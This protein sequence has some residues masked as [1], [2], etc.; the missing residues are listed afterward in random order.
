MV[1]VWTTSTMLLSYGI[2]FRCYVRQGRAGPGIPVKDMLC[3]PLSLNDH[4]YIFGKF[5]VVAV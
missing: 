5:R 4:I 1:Q 3:W 2:N